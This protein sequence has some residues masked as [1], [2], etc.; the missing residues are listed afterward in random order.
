[1]ITLINYFTKTTFNISMLL[2]TLC[3]KRRRRTRERAEEEERE[4][5]SRGSS[6]ERRGE[7]G[8]LG[9]KRRSS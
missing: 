3:G 7:R 5:E 6:R 8:G 4:R 2:G 9:T 1:L